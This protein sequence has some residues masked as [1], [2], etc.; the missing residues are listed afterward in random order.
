MNGCDLVA[1]TIATARKHGLKVGLYHSLNNWYDQPDSVAALEDPVAYEKFIAATHERI[2]ELV[3]RYPRQSAH[4]GEWLLP[5]R[6]QLAGNIRSLWK[7]II[8]RI[9][10]RTTASSFGIRASRFIDSMRRSSSN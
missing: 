4:A 2:R 8:S 3:T 1:E 9:R 5:L 7:S 6:H 10:R